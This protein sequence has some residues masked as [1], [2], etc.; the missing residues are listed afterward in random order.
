MV[1]AAPQSGVVLCEA[2]IGR[3]E[4]E[5]IDSRAKFFNP[6]TMDFRNKT[7][8]EPTRWWSRPM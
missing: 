2:V 7:S 6:S 8:I 4:V 5:R 3:E 1:I